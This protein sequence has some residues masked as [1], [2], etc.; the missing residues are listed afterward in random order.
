M[1]AAIAEFMAVN[2]KVHIQ[3]KAY[4]RPV[5]IIREGFDMVIQTGEP[6]LESASLVMRKLGE[7]SQCLGR[8]A[9]AARRGGRRPRSRPILPIGLRSALAH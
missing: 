2:L 1:G 3:L 7:V 4:N 8:G 6:R 9:A 5:D